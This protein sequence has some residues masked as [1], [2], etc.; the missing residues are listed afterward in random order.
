MKG[1]KKEAQ[2]EA[3]LEHVGGR[4]DSRRDGTLWTGSAKI[5]CSSGSSAHSSETR[6][7][8][9]VDVVVEESS[10]DVE[11]DVVEDRSLELA[12]S[13]VE[14]STSE[15]ELV[16]DVERETS[17]LVWVDCVDELTEG[18]L[19]EV[20]CDVIVGD[21]DTSLMLSLEVTR[22]VESVVEK[23]EEDEKVEMA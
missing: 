7:R 19:V 2:G 1:R 5:R 22:E 9:A 10:L 11:D 6:N 12:N 16:A 20:I 14:D 23:T 3:Y 15:V 13:D 8:V 4:A 17:V 18:W 21:V